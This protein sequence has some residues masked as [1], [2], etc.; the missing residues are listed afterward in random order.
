M[1]QLKQISYNCQRATY[2]IEKK[3]MAPLSI[4]QQLELRYHLAGCS[5]CRLY[6]EQ[7]KLIARKM[8]GFF[9]SKTESPASLDAGFKDKLKKL[10][11]DHHEEENG[12]L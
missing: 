5:V 7:S 2:L 12:I 10:I 9:A 3:Q 4:R 1:N 8:N 11:H 6:Q